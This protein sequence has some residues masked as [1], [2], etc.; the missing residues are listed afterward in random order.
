MPSTPL[1]ADRRG[2]GVQAARGFWRPDNLYSPCAAGYTLLPASQLTGEKGGADC[3]N[4]GDLQSPKRL[5]NFTSS[6]YLAT[7]RKGGEAA[8]GPVP[9][10][11]NGCAVSMER[12]QPFE[13]VA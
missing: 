12:E 5:G 7:E 11:A 1:S 2:E 3:L 4:Y 13:D 9:S 10:F 8:Q 6:F